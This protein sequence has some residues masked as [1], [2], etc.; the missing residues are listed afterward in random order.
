VPP[1]PADRTFWQW[2]KLP[3]QELM[4]GVYPNP[5]FARVTYQLSSAVW[6][7]C[8]DDRDIRFTSLTDLLAFDADYRQT[9]NG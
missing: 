5:A 8:H 3:R 2:Q 1:E 9:K 7:S 4:Q 6:R